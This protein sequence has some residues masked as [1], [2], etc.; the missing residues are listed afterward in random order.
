MDF[1]TKLPKTART[2]Y[3]T[4]WAIVDQLTKSSLF[5]PIRKAI[6]SEALARLFIKEVLTRVGEVAYRLELLK[7]LAGIHNTFHISYLCKCL[8]DDSMWVPLNNITLNNKL[9]YVEEPITIL[10]EKVKEIRNKRI[11]TYKVQWRNRKGSEYT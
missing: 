10:D 5:L 8:A 11:H 6:L 7:E 1:I 3:D 2:R 4:M 9:E